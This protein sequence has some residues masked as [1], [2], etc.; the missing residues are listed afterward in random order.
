MNQE[1]ILTPQEILHSEGNLLSLKSATAGSASKKPKILF[2][3]VE[4]INASARLGGNINKNA[5]ATGALLITVI[6]LTSFSLWVMKQWTLNKES[7]E[8]S[9][10][11]NPTF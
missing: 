4:K 3:D 11:N 6:V 5:D 10:E 1:K 9:S 7:Q 8:K 2:E